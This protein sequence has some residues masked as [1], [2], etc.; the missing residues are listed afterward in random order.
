M[1]IARYLAAA[2]VL[3]IATTAS[4]QPVRVR[5]DQEMVVGGV[6]VGCTGIGQT[7]N[8]PKWLA[9]PVRLEFANAARDY[10][11]DEAVTV[12]DASGGALLQVSCEGP[13]LLLKLPPGRPFR[14]EARLND[15]VT[16]PRTAEVTAPNRGQATVVITFPDAH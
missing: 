12:S 14:V 8:D 5:L 4:A 6:P 16:A 1:N 10:L 15:Q 2:V 3:A 11:A 13:W 9:Y 7:K